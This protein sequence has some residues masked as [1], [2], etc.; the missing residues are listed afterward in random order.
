METSM[1]PASDASGPLTAKEEETDNIFHQFRAVFSA[2]YCRKRLVYWVESKWGR[3]ILRQVIRLEDRTK[4]DDKVI[5]TFKG[6]PELDT[7]LLSIAGANAD[8]IRTGT[9]WEL[10]HNFECTDLWEMGRFDH[11]DLLGF[12]DPERVQQLMRTGKL[13]CPT[14]AEAWDFDAL[15]LTHRCPACFKNTGEELLV[16]D[17][18]YIYCNSCGYDARK[19]HKFETIRPV[20]ERMMKKLACHSEVRSHPVQHPIG[21]ISYELLDIHFAPIFAWMFNNI[22]ARAG[23]NFMN[24]G[25]VENWSFSTDRIQGIYQLSAYALM[26]NKMC[27]DELKQNIRSFYIMLHQQVRD[28]AFLFPTKD[29]VA[30]EEWRNRN[31]QERLKELDDNMDALAELD[32]LL[33]TK[34]LKLDAKESKERLI[35][36]RKITEAVMWLPEC[37]E[38]MVQWLFHNQAQGGVN[39]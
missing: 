16:F 17:P 8:T 3:T 32:T 20:I 5:A 11:I 21:N 7:L 10:Y 29:P 24:H 13:V 4:K 1:V 25:T 18:R 27:R 26:R 28:G 14:T 22:L 19:D 12:C 31:H 37:M 34:E 33:H 15:L 2:P 35:K 39:D 36:V 6:M 38:D 30:N 9:R 23:H